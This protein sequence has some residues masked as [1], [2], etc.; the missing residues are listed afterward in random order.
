MPPSSEPIRQQALAALTAELAA[1][2]HPANYAQHMAAAIIFQADLDLCTAQLARLLAWLKETQPEHYPDA[3][4]LVE[5]TRTEFE[6][7]VQ[8]G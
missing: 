4:A 3:L 7:R 2:G 1:Q 6:Q 8:N 5:S